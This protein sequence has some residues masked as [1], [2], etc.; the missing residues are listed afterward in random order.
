M[1]HRK[2]SPPPKVFRL[3]EF[4]E[5]L[6]QRKMSGSKLDN[7]TSHD[8]LWNKQQIEVKTSQTQSPNSRYYFDIR[9]QKREGNTD[10]FFILILD[11]H[12]RELRHAYLIPNKAITAQVTLNICPGRSKYER[13]RLQLKPRADH[14]RVNP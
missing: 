8:L 7:K 14:A 3:G 6:A 5:L 4:G 13:Y 2:N 9:I 11:E 10:F 1:Y 12:T